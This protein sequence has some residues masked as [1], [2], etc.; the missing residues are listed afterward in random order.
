VL[1]D[2]YLD[3]AIETEVDAVYDG[4]DLFIGA[5]MEHIEPAGVHSGDANIVLPSI[6]LSKK[7]KQTIEDYTKK[8]ANALKT[9]G[10]INIQYAVKDGIVYML[11][12]N[13]G[14]ASKFNL[15]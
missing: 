2:K 7:E 1:I 10:L 8:I 5:I 12:A 4:E 9:I 13:P 3:N 14:L 6:R 15:S 11:E